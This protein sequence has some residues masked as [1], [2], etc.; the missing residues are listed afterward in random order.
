MSTPTTAVT[1][2]R[3]FCQAEEQLLFSVNAGIPV[4]HAIEHASHLLR[5]IERLAHCRSMPERI[6]LQYLTEMCRALVDACQPQDPE[7]LA[8]GKRMAKEAREAQI[9][10]AEPAAD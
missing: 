10:A 2:S 1:D 8:Q 6:A 9:K 3:S 5:C 7:F 4:D